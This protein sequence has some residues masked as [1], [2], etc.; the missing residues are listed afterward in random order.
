MAAAHGR[1][2]Y[3][4]VGGSRRCHALAP[5]TAIEPVTAEPYSPYP[6][7]VPIAAAHHNVAAVLSPVMVRPFRRIT[8]APKKTDPGDYLARDAKT[9]I[10]RA[11]GESCKH[12]EHGRTGCYQRIGT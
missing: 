3:Q 2:A 10:G 9:V 6:A 4:C 8:P 5:I 7:R 11:G 1:A 12:D